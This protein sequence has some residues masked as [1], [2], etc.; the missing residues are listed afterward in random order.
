MMDDVLSTS[1]SLRFPAAFEA[2]EGAIDRWD[3]V[4]QE[5][6]V[7]G[8]MSSETLEGLGACIG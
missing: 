4:F 8:G 3:W 2:R 1:M 6:E 5:Q 7:G